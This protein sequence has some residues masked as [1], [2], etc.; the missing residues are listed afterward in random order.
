MVGVFGSVLVSSRRGPLLT[1]MIGQVG[2]QGWVQIFRMLLTVVMNV[3][4][5]P[6]GTA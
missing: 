4:P 6:G 3:V 1:I 2:L 5:R